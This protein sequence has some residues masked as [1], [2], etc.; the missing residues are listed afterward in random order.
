M[1]G[2]FIIE[3]MT[4]EAATS[5]PESPENEEEASSDEVQGGENESQTVL[6][7]GTQKSSP[8]FDFLEFTAA[9]A[10]LGGLYAAGQSGQLWIGV[11][12]GITLLFIHLERHHR[13]ELD[14]LIERAQANQSS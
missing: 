9:G 7:E 11:L 5:K 10:C 2:W 3:T 6:R 8:L 14:T 1:C 13:K 12:V 4:P